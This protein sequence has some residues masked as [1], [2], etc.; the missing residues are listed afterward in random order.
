MAKILVVDDDPQIR[1]VLGELLAREGHEIGECGDG[2]VAMEMVDS[3]K[4]DLMV[5]DLML[6]RMSGEVVATMIKGDERTR[7]IPIIVLTGESDPH[8]HMHILNIGVEEFLQKPFSK[9]QLLA[10]VRSLVAVKALND[11][12]LA[13]FRAVELLEHLSAELIRGLDNADLE[14][15]SF[16]ERSLAGWLEWDALIG[17]PSHLW[18]CPD[19]GEELKGWAIQQAGAAGVQRRAISLRR[20]RLL[21]LMEPYRQGPD[22]YWSNSIPE[23]ILAALW[24]DLPASRTLVGI[25][26]GE[27]WVLSAGHARPVGVHD[28]R[29]L[30]AVARQYGVFQSYL[31]QLRATDE[32]FV[33][34]MGALARAAEVHDEATFAHIQRVNAYSAVLAE[35]LGCGS[36]FV[37]KIRVSAQ[38]HDVG[39]IHIAESILRKPGLLNKDEM[40]IVRRHPAFGAQILGDSPRLGMAREIAL[41]HHEKWDGTGYP[42][43][44]QGDKI[45]LAARIVALADVY[46]ALRTPRTYKPS[47]EHAEAEHVIVNGDGRTMPNHFDPAVLNAFKATES[48]F[49]DIYESFVGAFVPR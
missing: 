16:L 25:H 28:T 18:V 9:W 3:F 43:G 24:H 4:P 30:S 8:T 29:W 11:Q 45:P 15:E 40:D 17:A 10:R 34:T 38:M 41:S 7:L 32:A 13:S 5:L 36:G 44:L 49:K 19:V 33:Y 1:A 22:S 39:K 26:E 35:W 6:P 20:E 12:L 31:R 23:Y 21:S 27:L 42:N 14:E 47:Q 37:A 48:R 46:D 2:V